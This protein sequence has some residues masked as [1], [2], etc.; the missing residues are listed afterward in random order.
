MNGTQFELFTGCEMKIQAPK[1]ETARNYPS[2]EDALDQENNVPSDFFAEM[3]MSMM[4]QP[5][6]SMETQQMQATDGT[7]NAELEEAVIQTAP[8]NKNQNFTKFVDLAIRSTQQSAIMQASPDDKKPQPKLPESIQ[9][10]LLAT[11]TPTPKFATWLDDKTTSSMMTD[12]QSQQITT[13]TAH[14]DNQTIDLLNQL[15]EKPIKKVMI[16]EMNPV[17]PQNVKEN[18]NNQIDLTAIQPVSSQKEES[19]LE[20]EHDVTQIFA[21]DKSAKTIQKDNNP[22]TQALTTLGSMIQDQAASIGKQV[23]EPKTIETTFNDAKRAAMQ[24][25]E[26]A[27]AP[28]RVDIMGALESV[29]KDV[30]TANIKIY[31]PELGS[32]IAKLK[33]AKNTAELTLTTENDRVKQIVEANLP[34]LRDHFIRSDLNLVSIDV[35]V[36]LANTDVG[37]QKPKQQADQQKS[38]N[39]M[40][41]QDANNKANN[42]VLIKKRLNSLVDTYV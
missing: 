37:D 3:M 25:N 1:P 42:Q 40:P 32:V 16:G 23:S 7:V 33:I 39:A 14:V 13:E 28:V 30:Y 4:M 31:P 35:R 9:A 36:Q 21:A 38:D 11:L 2:T 10:D 6:A 27:E 26:L 15:L 34:A 41:E 17:M 12:D 29:K 20:N 19:T 8:E 24:M 18:E 5:V 22:Y